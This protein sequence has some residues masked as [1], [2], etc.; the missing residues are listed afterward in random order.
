VHVHDVRWDEGGTV[1]AGIIFFSMKK[2]MKTIVGNRIFCTPQQL[3]ESS[4]L[5]I[6]CHTYIVLRCHWCN[7]ISN[8]H[9]QSEEKCDD[10]KGSFYEE[11]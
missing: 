4:L 8:V 7:I 10:S 6:G 9:A 3:R 2:E 5:A 11:L 1:R